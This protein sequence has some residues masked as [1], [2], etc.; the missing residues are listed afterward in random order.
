MRPVVWWLALSGL[1]FCRAVLGAPE[2]PLR[3]VYFDDFA[4]Y[5]W[6]DDQGK[7][8]GIMVDVMDRAA[9]ELGI[10]VTHQGYP[11]QRAQKL[12]RFA[13]A[14]G[15][16]SVATRER[17]QFTRVVEEPVTTTVLTLF[18]GA[19]HP[20]LAQLQQAR[21]LAEFKRFVILD[22]IGNGWGKVH[23]QGFKVHLTKN[24]DNVFQ[25]LAAG[26]GDLMITDPLV[27][28]FKL[29]Q[30][31]LDDRIVELPLRL[32]VTTFHLCIGDHSRFKNRAEDFERV[33]HQL[34]ERGELA[35]I[36]ARYR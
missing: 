20:D 19:A 18:T 28:W 1:L 30:L 15:F 35:R 10:R 27:A 34:R 3:M 26:R 32:D 12:V 29:K 2:S 36:E 16:V 23:L 11:W 21:T 22:Y 31:G 5:S 24:V 17:R 4:P 9:D 25:M 7:M 33:L 14:D 13:Q 6:R 8:R